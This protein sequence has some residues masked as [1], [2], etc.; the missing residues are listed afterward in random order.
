M[1]G[2]IDVDSETD[3][4]S[5]FWFRAVFKKQE[6]TDLS[7]T[8]GHG[9]RGLRVL[10]VDDN[11]T[12]RMVVHHLVTSWG[13]RD[14]T[15][16]GATQALSLLRRACAGGDPYALAILDMEMPLMDGEQLARAIKADAQL[17][18][19]QL[20]MLTSRGKRPMRD[21]ME[22]GLAA[23]LSKPVKKSELFD[24]LVDV[25]Q[26][27]G[28]IGLPDQE[29]KS[30]SQTVGND[31]TEAAAKP[32]RGV[33]V[34][35]V[36]DNTINQKVAV[37]MLER[38]GCSPDV[39]GDG[40]EAVETVAMIPYDIV[41]MDC[42]MPEMDGYEATAQIRRNEGT[43]KH[44][45]IIAMTANALKGDKELCLAAGMDDYIAK[46]IRSGDLLAV[47][48]RQLS[49]CS[50]DNTGEANSMQEKSSQ[51][52]G[53]DHEVLVELQSLAEGH[54]PEFFERV[55]KLFLEEAPQRLA[56]LRESA[57]SHDAKA[58]KIGAHKLR[59]SCRQLGI[60]S[61][62]E[63]CMSLEELA[64]MFPTSDGVMSLLDQ[65]QEQFEAAREEFETKYLSGNRIR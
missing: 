39:A 49:L 64:S 48:E 42:Q 62:A 40:R 35:V 10:V 44:T 26:A 37:R 29:G 33:R 45:R 6:R 20:V 30:F 41:L 31:E 5:T 17:A 50:S 52:S 34:L 13:M 56:S 4:G 59:G 36:E 53:L 46:P 55:I 28:V 22:A 25:M 7:D 60:V 24:S 21:V 58:L 14:E 12:N 23:C 16:E 9:L 2:R 1:G 54:D 15:T 32:L 19:T 65:L 3:K 63:V 51:G 38:L 18:K 11:E 47:I 8:N 43:Q 57:A 61:M 27:A